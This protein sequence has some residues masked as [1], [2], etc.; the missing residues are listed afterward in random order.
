MGYYT[1]F[2]LTVTGETD[3]DVIGAFRDENDWAEAALDEDGRNMD[4]CK[5]YNCKEDVLEFSKKHP[6]ILFLLEGEGEEAG[7]IW[8]FYARNGKGCYQKAKIVFEQFDESMLV[9]G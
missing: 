6:D 7:D 8:K 4:E 3:I 9:E 5:W 1:R 2:K